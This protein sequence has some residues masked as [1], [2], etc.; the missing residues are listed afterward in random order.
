MESGSVVYQTEDLVYIH[1]EAIVGDRQ[2]ISFTLDSIFSQLT[3]GD[4]ICVDFD[5]ADF[6]MIRVESD[7]LLAT[8]IQGGG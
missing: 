2:N 8:V 6:R 1:S 4:E 3:E 5:S 7:Q